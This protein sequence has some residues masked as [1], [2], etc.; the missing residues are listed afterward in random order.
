M[1]TAQYRVIDI[2]SRNEE[3]F[4]LSQGEYDNFQKAQAVILK[5]IDLEEVY[6]QTIE[7][8]FDY[9]NMINYWSLRSIT[10]PFGNH[11]IN[12]EIR[13]SLNKLAFNV[14]NLGKLYLDKHYNVDKRNCFSSDLNKS[15]E[16][17]NDIKLH[18]CK[19]YNENIRYVIGCKLRSSSQ[20]NLFPVQSFSTTL[21]RIPISDKGQISFGIKVNHEK[22]KNIG[23]PDNKIDADCEYD[24]TDI[25]SGYI[26]GISEMHHYNRKL[27]FDKLSESKEIISRLMI[28][29]SN[30]SEYSDYYCVVIEDTGKMLNANLDW[31]ELVDYLQEKHPFSVDY[32]ASFH[33]PL[34]I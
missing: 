9:R 29:Y 20:H 14:L 32:S 6:D 27:Y 8:F 16:I 33:E 5:I 17:K 26:Y 24:L 3:S 18:R 23:I 2:A 1:T 11:K 25:L 4:E 12:H 13:G 21:K 22:L 19:I 7:S 10:I 15:E 34:K 30:K 31:T 28:Y